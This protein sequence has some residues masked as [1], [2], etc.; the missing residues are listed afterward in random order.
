VQLLRVGSTLASAAAAFVLA[1]CVNDLPAARENVSVADR[2][3][4]A[5]FIRSIRARPSDKIKHVVIIIQENR[6]VDNLF[7]GL[8]RADTRSYGFDTNGKK[9]RLRPVGLAAKWDLDHSSTAFFEDCDGRGVYPGTYCKMDGFDNEYWDC[10]KSGYP[11][12]PN[13]NPPYSYVPHTETKSYFAI[14]AQYVF[15]DRMFSSNFDGSSFVSHQYIIAAESQS[16]VD[17]PQGWWGCYGGSGDTIPT[18][19]QQRQ[20][21]G[22]SI[23]VCFPS[24]TLGDELDDAHLSWKYYASAD[25]QDGGEWSAYQAVKHIYYGAD[26]KKDVISPQT[27]FFTDVQN[28]KLPVVSWITPTCENSDHAGCGAKTGPSW[29]ASLVNAIGES[30]YWDSTAIFIFWDDFGGWYDHVAPS[31]V[32]YDG[33]GFR[34]P[35]LIVSAYARKGHVTHVRYEHGSILRFIEERFGLSTLSS[36]DGRANVPGNDIFDFSASPRAF[37]TI[38]S[39]HDV[40]YFMHQRPDE[41]PPDRE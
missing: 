34:M 24:K 16:A 15:A 19:T 13:S 14:A 27:I 22:S 7:Q 12:C 35:M 21:S 3:P 41:R 33:Y 23:P 1:S 4:A 6:S 10:G 8:P 2:A 37:S 9:I 39:D 11:P 29:V 31:F 5:A 17:Y 32:D 30:K 36:S 20:I 40:N 18:V 25:N 28:G 38:P 26:W